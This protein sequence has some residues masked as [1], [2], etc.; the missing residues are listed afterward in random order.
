MKKVLKFLLFCSILALI[1]VYVYVA[2]LPSIREKEEQKQ[3]EITVTE[4]TFPDVA[5]ILGDDLELKY[6][7]LPVAY[8]GQLPELPTGCEITA[9]TT[10]LNYWGYPVDKQTMADTYLEKVEPFAAGPAEAFIGSPWQ[11][12]G[13]G[14]FAPVITKSANRFLTDQQSEKKAYDITG[15][16]F[17][18]LC[19]ELEAGYPVI[20]WN[21][22]DIN[23]PSSP[24]P[25]T[26]NDGRSVNWYS[27]EHCVVF[28]GYNLVDNTVTLA[29]PLEGIVERD[30][31]TFIARYEELG[32]QAVVIK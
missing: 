3:A 8:V 10:V 32:R 22:Q 25:I 28:I 5:S 13:W 16:D 27:N 1:G 30:F 29:D 7:L 14:C 6:M 20:V 2:Y 4:V 23:K 21:T 11:T 26:L 19:T 31:N 17:E 15:A 9:L 24:V 18:R 12:D